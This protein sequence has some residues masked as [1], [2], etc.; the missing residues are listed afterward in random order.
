MRYARDDPIVTRHRRRAC[1]TRYALLLSRAL[2]LLLEEF[3]E[4]ERYM[5]SLKPRKLIKPHL[6][7]LGRALKHMGRST[8][9]ERLKRVG[10]EAI[11]AAYGEPSSPASAND[12]PP[13]AEPKEGPQIVLPGAERIPDA[14]LAKRRAGAPLRAKKPQEPPG[15]LFS[16]GER[17]KQ[18]DLEEAINKAARST[19]PC[20]KPSPSTISSGSLDQSG[21]NTEKESMPH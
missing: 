12:K 17:Q 5:Q 3:P 15:G 13:S 1:G 14:E 16:Q 2:L 8:G 19:R 21:K 18:I 7:A 10:H 4:V 9:Q 20:V 6:L 11:Q